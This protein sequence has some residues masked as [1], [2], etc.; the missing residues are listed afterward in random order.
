VGRSV[1][2]RLHAF[3]ALSALFL[4][5]ALLSGV[6]W[7]SD[8]D[9]D[10][11]VDGQTALV[12]VMAD[13]DSLDSGDSFAPVSAALLRT[14]GSALEPASIAR[15][16]LGRPLIPA[17]SFGTGR[18][19]V[20]ADAQTVISRV[21]DHLE[22]VDSK[23]AFAPVGASVL[24]ILLPAFPEQPAVAGHLDDQVVEVVHEAGMGQS[25]TLNPPPPI[26]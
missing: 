2:S 14:L 19:V 10:A 7:L 5:L 24:R 8:D 17:L 20:G 9:A 6:G 4:V 16:S 26:L 23:D 25:Q 21:R 3:S 11:S 18:T 1:G 13:L 15:Y 22:S 12:D